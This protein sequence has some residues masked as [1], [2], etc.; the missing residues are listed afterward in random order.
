M[1]MKSGLVG[2]CFKDLLMGKCLLF[3]G[4]ANVGRG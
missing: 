4:L 3:L 2:L 1:G